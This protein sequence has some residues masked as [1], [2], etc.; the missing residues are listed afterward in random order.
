MP[1][2]LTGEGPRAD[3]PPGDGVGGPRGEDGVDELVGRGE[4]GGEAGQQGPAGARAG[5][6]V[7]RS[8]GGGW[9]G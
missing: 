5:G 2:G 9:G 4:F 1:V 6:R 7:A 3:R 8:A